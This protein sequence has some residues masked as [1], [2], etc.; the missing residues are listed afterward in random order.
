M[1]GPVPAGIADVLVSGGWRPGHRDAE[2]ARQW[3]VSL[4][5]YTA[6]D[7][8]RHTIVAPAV[9][10]YAEFGGVRVEAGDGGEQV[11]RSAFA[12]DPLAIRH[13]VLTLAGLAA[14]LGVAVSPLGEEAAGAGILAIDERGRVFVIDHTAEWWLGDTVVDA[15]ECL[16]L[17]RMPARLRQDGT[18]R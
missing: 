12:I 4:A 17:G 9:A 14:A 7:G 3:A 8:R 5:A 10:A 15:F 1:T 2:R 18:W 11:A 6:P 13:S 16:I